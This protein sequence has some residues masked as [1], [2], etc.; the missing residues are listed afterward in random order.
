MVAEIDDS[1]FRRRW[2]WVRSRGFQPVE[3]LDLSLPG[4]LECMLACS[5]V[6]TLDL[7][8]VLMTQSLVEFLLCSFDVKIGSV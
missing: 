5:L 7:H 6:E 3:F 2:S 4:G 8:E 1:A